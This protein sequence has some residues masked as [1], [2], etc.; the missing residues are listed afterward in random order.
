MT[1]SAVWNRWGFG[2]MLPFSLAVDRQI[3]GFHRWGIAAVVKMS[4]YAP[5]S[6]RWPKS[7]GETTLPVAA[8]NISHHLLRCGLGN[9]S[10]IARLNP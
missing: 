4:G 6:S 5:G 3:V 10:A 8:L 1:V 9:T 2:R 7:P